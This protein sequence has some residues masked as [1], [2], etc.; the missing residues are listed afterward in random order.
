LPIEDIKALPALLGRLRRHAHFAAVCATAADET[1]PRLVPSPAAGGAAKQRRTATHIETRVELQLAPP[2]SLSLLLALPVTE[3]S[4]WA[5]L[6]GRAPREALAELRLE[7]G[8]GGAAAGVAGVAWQAAL[9]SANGDAAFEGLDAACTR[10]VELCHSLPL[11]VA[12]LHERLAK[13]P[14]D[15]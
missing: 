9:R 4:R 10:M 15:Q 11:T 3:D 12:A 13:G 7:V 5:S 14:A 8:E 6:P 2:L 1:F